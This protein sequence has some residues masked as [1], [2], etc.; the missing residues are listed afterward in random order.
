[1]GD[2]VTIYGGV[3]LVVET[4]EMNTLTIGETQLPLNLTVDG[5]ADTDAPFT[6]SLLTWNGQSTD[7]EETQTDTLVLTSADSTAADGTYVWSFSGSVYKQLSASGINYMVFKVGQQ[8]VAL[9]TAGF[10]AGVRYNLYRM[11]GLASKAFDYAVTMDAQGGFSLS[12]TVEGQT[13]AL[14][15]DQQSEFYYYNVLSGTVDMLTRPFGQADGQS[16]AA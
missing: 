13:Y 6:A 15:A 10:A 5:H 14:T 7:T 16:N 1:M 11:A 2:S 8:A 4:G 3:D 12:V 9:S